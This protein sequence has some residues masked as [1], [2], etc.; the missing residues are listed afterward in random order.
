MYPKPH[1]KIL[2]REY[3]SKP[4][5]GIP[6]A[7][8]ILADPETHRDDILSC[9][10]YLG[11][12][13]LDETYTDINFLWPKIVDAYEM[14]KTISTPNDP[15]WFRSRWISSYLILQVYFKLLIFNEDTPVDLLTT[16]AESE[17]A[18]H[19]PPQLPNVMRSHMILLLH[20]YT[21]NQIDVA[22]KLTDKMIA[23]YKKSVILNSFANDV[24]VF[25]ITEATSCV[26]LAIQIKGTS[27][28]G[29]FHREYYAEDLIK[30]ELGNKSYGF[31]YKCLH[32]IYSRVTFFT[33]LKSGGDYNASHV[34]NLKNG[35]EKHTN[36][37]VNFVCLSDICI[38][39][40]K[41]IPLTDNLTGWWSKMELFKFSGPIVYFDLDTIVVGDLSPIMEVARKNQ[42]CILRDI[43]L[44][45]K[46]PTAMGS[47]IMTWNSNMKYLYEVFMKTPKYFM[48]FYRGDQNFIQ[49]AIDK[50]SVK[51]LQDVV[52]GFFSSFKAHVR[53]KG[54][55][56]GT[57]VV[58]F[59]GPPRPWEQNEI[60][61]N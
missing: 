14:A 54:I 34:L 58:V 53:G 25:E 6:L 40:V 42:F 17:H 47:G 39:G 32:T 30:S 36:E 35:I 28:D 33:V 52:P 51:F 43:Y 18:F 45:E 61:Y 57:K 9:V 3:S 60:P 10:C 1:L 31:Y 41:T 48:N 16:L 24:A 21:T 13:V 11:Y 29:M 44:G 38:E 59:H 19:H 50:P 4:E 15:E 37:S 23:A 56:E 49:Y 7:L 55:P 8:E 27:I 26:M 46:N 12:R 2:G 22:H 20:Y 5:I